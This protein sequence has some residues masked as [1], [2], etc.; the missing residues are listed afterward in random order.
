MRGRLAITLAVLAAISG[1]ST[2]SHAACPYLVK[3]GR[4]CPTRSQALRSA[5]TPNLVLSCEQQCRIQYSPA[6]ANEITC[7]MN[8]KGVKF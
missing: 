6:S 3:I 1:I 5:K 2:A 7:E 4:P 8:C